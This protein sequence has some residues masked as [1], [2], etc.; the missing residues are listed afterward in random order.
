MFVVLSTQL[1]SK[2][3][4][5]T[6]GQIGSVAV[7][8]QMPDPAQ[9]EQGPEQ[10]SLQHTP[11]AQELLAHSAF[12][13]QEVPTLFLGAEQLPALSHRLVALQT[14]PLARGAPEHSWAAEP[15]RPA[16]QRSRVTLAGKSR[17]VVSAGQ[18]IAPQ[19][20]SSGSGSQARPD[21]AQRRH[22]PS[23][24][25]V[26]QTLSPS[27][28]GWQRPAP[29]SRSDRQLSPAAARQPSRARL[30]PSTPHSASVVHCPPLQRWKLD[31]EHCAAPSSQT[32]AGSQP[33]V[34]PQTSFGAQATAQ[35]TLPPAAVATQAPLP[36]SA[37]ELQGAR[38]SRLGRLQLPSSSHSDEA[39]HSRLARRGSNTVQA[40]A[41]VAQRPSRQRSVATLGGS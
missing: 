36:H 13:V 23:H 30:Q 14:W 10:A 1:A 16:T 3:L 33:P 38:S 6:V 8:R 27:A 18:E 4:Q 12:V 29:Q 34:A 21:G 31:P 26:Q 11:S 37:S 24:T 40:S 41:G 32:G 2:R 9:V 39:L 20:S 22:G 15:Q 35:H 25:A 5:E 17:Q 19:A 7:A 28:V